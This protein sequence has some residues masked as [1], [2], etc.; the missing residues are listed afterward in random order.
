MTHN[1]SNLDIV[2]INAY[3]KFGQIHEFISKILS[4]NEILTSI[5]GHNSVFDLWKLTCNNPN[6]DVFNI[7]AYAK[8]GQ[9]SS[10]CSK[11][12]ERKRNSDNNHGP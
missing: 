8:F 10:I 2:N 5:K 7:N 9:I 11:D 4:E 3:A 6:L 1:N 12:I